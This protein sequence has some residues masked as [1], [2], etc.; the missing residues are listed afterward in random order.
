VSK[1]VASQDYS[2]VYQGRHTTVKMHVVGLFPVFVAVG[3]VLVVRH[4]RNR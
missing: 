1:V 4:E 3:T 2:Y